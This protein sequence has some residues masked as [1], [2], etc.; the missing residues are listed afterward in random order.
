MVGA[1]RLTG[2]RG[3]DIVGHLSRKVLLNISRLVSLQKGAIATHRFR[4]VRRLKG[5][6]L[7]RAIPLARLYSRPVRDIGVGQR[8]NHIITRSRLKK[9]KT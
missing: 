4:Q 3:P 5:C 9:A 8:D 1:P 6:A 2:A 7:S